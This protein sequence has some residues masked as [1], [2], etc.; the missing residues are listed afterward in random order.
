M[1]IDSLIWL[2]QVG[3]FI[4]MMLFSKPIAQNDVQVIKWE[5]TAI[6]F[7]IQE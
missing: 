3:K 2:Q 7:N 4:F 6:N 5:E 1:P